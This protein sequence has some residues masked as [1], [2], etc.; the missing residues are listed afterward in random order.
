MGGKVVRE[1]CHRKE[2]CPFLR[3]FI[4]KDTKVGFKFLVHPLCFFISL[5]IVGKGELEVIL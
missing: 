2:V 5:W 3:V 1:F 4:T